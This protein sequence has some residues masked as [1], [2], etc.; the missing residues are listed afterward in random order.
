MTHNKNEID[1]EE[2]E[3]IDQ[4]VGKEGHI[5][6]LTQN[7]HEQRNSLFQKDNI[8]L[9]KELF[10]LNTCL[11]RNSSTLWSCNLSRALYL[12]SQLLLLLVKDHQFSLIHESRERKNICCQNCKIL[13]PRKACKEI[14]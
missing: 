3:D 2:R 5:Q 11:G 1:G 14:S 6:I 13:Q 7:L 9:Q 8:H 4:L 10:K 12:F